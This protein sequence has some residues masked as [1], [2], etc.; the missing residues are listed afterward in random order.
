GLRIA[1][2][3]AMEDRLGMAGP[4]ATPTIDL[5]TPS[6]AARQTPPTVPMAVSAGNGSSAPSVA[7]PGYDIIELIDQGGMGMV[8]RA[9][10]TRLQRT[11]A[12]K[13]MTAH[14]SSVKHATRFQ[15]EAEAVARLQHPHI[16]QIFE[17][18]QADGRPYFAMEYM[19]GGTLAARMSRQRPSP[20]R[21]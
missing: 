21:A 13:M 10:Q 20:R 14:S 11:V 1:A 16:V 8:Y 17:I 18:G 5:V 19:A 2:I 7:I 15:A 9:V 3:R 12:I 6:G 4:P